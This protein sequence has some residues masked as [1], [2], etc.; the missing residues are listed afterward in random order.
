[1]M[2]EEP[3]RICLYPPKEFVEIARKGL[4]ILRA[5]HSRAGGYSY[6]VYLGKSAC[7]AEFRGARHVVK[8]T[9]E[10]GMRIYDLSSAWRKRAT[11]QENLL[12]EKIEG[13]SR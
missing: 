6:D 4:Q 1:M 9:M 11:E 7:G 12:F 2:V 3:T 5:C 13:M 8:A 10:H